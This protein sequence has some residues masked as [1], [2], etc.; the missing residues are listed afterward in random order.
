MIG[1]RH[2]LIVLRQRIFWRQQR[3]CRDRVV[4][5]GVEVRVVRNIGRTMK[6]GVLHRHL[7]GDA[8]FH[9]RRERSVLLVGEEVGV[10]GDCARPAAERLMA[11][12]G[13]TRLVASIGRSWAA[14][15]RRSITSST[16]RSAASAKI[17]AWRIGADVT[18]VASA[19]GAFGCLLG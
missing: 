8:R 3:T 13:S 1:D 7:T 12:T 9:A 17:A 5:A 19:V 10:D 14:G 18:S 16:R 4:N 2:P 6:D 11:S 15:R